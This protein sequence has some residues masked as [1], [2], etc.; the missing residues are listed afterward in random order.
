MSELN[1]SRFKDIQ[2]GEGLVPQ[3]A[4]MPKWFVHI[5]GP[6]DVIAKSDEL[7]ALRS[8]NAENVQ[9]EREQS[10]HANNPNHP[11]MIAIARKE[12]TL[13]LSS[14]RLTKISTRIN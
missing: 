10:R 11:F 14:D 9:I 5:V 1:E 7:D 13:R 12:G 3:E 6:D 2:P 8:A 4:P